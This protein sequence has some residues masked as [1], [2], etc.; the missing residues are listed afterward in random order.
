MQSQEERR[1]WKKK[2]KNKSEEDDAAA[3]GEKLLYDMVSFRND[4]DIVVSGVTAMTGFWFLCIFTF[5]FFLYRPGLDLPVE[6][7]DIHQ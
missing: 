4:G 7:V 6:M 2:E 3:V 1:R 5:F